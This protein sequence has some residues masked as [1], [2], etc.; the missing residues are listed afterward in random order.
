M[1][2]KKRPLR[3]WIIMFLFFGI[4]TWGTFKIIYFAQG[5]FNKNMISFQK[6][7]TIDHKEDKNFYTC[8]FQN[9]MAIYDQ[10]IIKLYDEKGDEEWAVRKKII[11]PMIVTAKNILFLGNKSTGEV[12][13]INNKGKIIWSFNL[14]NSF[15]K[16][17][18]SEEG[19]LAIHI[20]SSETNEKIVIINPNGNTEGEVV[21]SDS[22]IIDFDIAEKGFIAVSAM[23][24]ENDEIHSNIILYSFKGKLL[25]GN[26]YDEEIISNLFFSS[27][28]EL[29]YVGTGSIGRFNKEKGLRWSKEVSDTIR[30]FTWNPQGWIA[31]SMADF[32]KTITDLK[33]QN[34]IL[35]IDNSGKE[36]GKY[37]VNGNILGLASRQNNL[38]AFTERTLYIFKKGA[39]QIADK[40]ISNDIQD[41]Y[42]LPQDRLA[43]VFKN[44][45]EIFQIKYRK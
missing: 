41:V 38:A 31:I 25:G 8:P 37:V 33:N 16:L 7:N 9:G 21:L 6:I 3:F 15:R 20:E 24:I 4:L 1:R 45:T 2:K 26:K 43:L 39:K 36:T 32:K 44:K 28:S 34:Y 13:A 30:G 35:I 14:N 29:F 11:N 40:K 42:L 23:D 17:K 22:I 19:Y 10:D 18:A 5:I 12:V 27:D